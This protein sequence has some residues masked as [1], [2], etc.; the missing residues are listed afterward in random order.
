MNR[1]IIGISELKNLIQN[2]KTKKGLDFSNYAF[3][4]LKHR[5]EIFMLRFH[6]ININE[7]IQK[8]NKDEYFY[9]LFLKDI[10]VDSTELFR[11]PEFW[12]EL[13]ISNKFKISKDIKILIPECNSGEELYT[14]LI[15]LD[16]LNILGRVKV[17]LTSLS[18]LNI[19]KIRNA[20]ID[21]KKMELNSA[22]FERF[23]EN[24]N[25]FDFFIKKGPIVKFNTD[26]IKN[27]EII[28]H[29]L[30]KD[31]LSENYNLILY[32][33]KTIYYNQQL[34]TEVLKILGSLLKT[35]GFIAVGIKE[36]IDFPG[37]EREFILVN[38]SEKIY[39]KI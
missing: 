23:N 26:L 12:H 18:H 31:E 25:I 21:L 22:N 39:K 30:F 36:T 27:V 5:I 4:S 8:I 16:Q 15:I 35:N 10:L 13:K 37:V 24:G 20:T 19:E 17:V 14:L 34:K 3:S 11:D 1:L 28:H 7:L 6:F 38:D 2:I 32:R 9:E 33:N 29:N